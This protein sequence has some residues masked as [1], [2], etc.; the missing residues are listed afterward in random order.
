MNTPHPSAPVLV[1]VANPTV[2]P[3][4]LHIVAATGRECIDTTDPREISRHAHRVAAV[5]VDATTA[6]HM[7]SLPPNTRVMYL[8]AEPGPIDYEKAMKSGAE[9]AV[10]VPAQSPELLKALGRRDVAPRAGK[11]PVIAVIGAAGGAGTS[12]LC[13]VL[14]A[15]YREALLIDTEHF[16]GGIDLLLGKEDD[17]GIRWDDVPDSGEKVPA[18]EL[19]ASL[20][21]MEP[22]VRILAATRDSVTVVA[23][24]QLRGVVESVRGTCPIIIDVQRHHVLLES[25]VDLADLVVLLI[26]AEIRSVAAAAQLVPWLRR[27][28]VDVVGVLRERAWAS[29]DREEVAR[30]TGVDIVATVPTIKGLPREVELGGMATIPRALRRPLAQLRSHID[31]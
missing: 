6:P 9:L 1:A 2:H 4:A 19:L 5:L 10:I 8:E 24:Q 14:A 29:V 12:T 7:A 18:S 3:E 22:N 27:R 20:P 30:V 16:S 31:G 26:P 15:D 28:K 11:Y 13:A 17:P 21:C 23:E 25:C